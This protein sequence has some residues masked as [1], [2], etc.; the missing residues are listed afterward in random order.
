M[1]SLLL[2]LLLCM[3]WPSSMASS[4]RDSSIRLCLLHDSWLLMGDLKSSL[5]L[6]PVGLPPTAHALDHLTIS[7]HV[8]TTCSGSVGGRSPFCRLSWHNGRGPSLLRN[9]PTNSKLPL[10]DA[11]VLGLHASKDP[12]I[13]QSKS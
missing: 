1:L 2:L 6:L 11:A 10:I 5:V 8:P 3:L 4:R 9:D 12:Q 7:M 13:R